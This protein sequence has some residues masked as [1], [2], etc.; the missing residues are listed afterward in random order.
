M[1]KAKKRIAKGKRSSTRKEQSIQKRPSTWNGSLKP[2][3]KNAPVS[4]IDIKLWMKYLKIKNFQGVVSRDKII[5]CINEGFYVVNLDTSAGP[6]THLVA[7][8]IK[9][10]IIEYFD[11]FGLNCPEEVIYL[12]DI[13]GVNYIYNSSQYQDLMSV[14]C[15][16]YCIYWINE[17]YKEKSYY[18]AIKVFDITDT[19]YNEKLVKLLFYVYNY[20]KMGNK[21]KNVKLFY[22]I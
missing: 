18:D 7:M 6:G 11:S 10:D 5:N 4:T 21:N 13:L 19:K 3:F 9:P 15:G 22:V 14:L 1:L 16:Y 12:S 2:K 8:C 20:I 17:I